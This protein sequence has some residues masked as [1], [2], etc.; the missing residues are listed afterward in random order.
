M[1]KR[2]LR[3]STQLRTAL[4]SGL[5]AFIAILVIF[6]H[7]F[8]VE[9]LRAIGNRAFLGGFGT[10]LIITVLVSILGGGVGLALGKLLELNNYLSRSSLQSLRV[11]RWLPFFVFW[12]LP[13]W[14][15][16]NTRNG[17]PIVI[18]LTTIT[19]G[20]IAAGPTILLGACYYHLSYRARLRTEPRSVFLQI[21]GS[22]FLLALLI[23]LLF[24]LLFND[25]W[26]WRWYLEPATVSANSVAAFILVLAVIVLTIVIPRSSFDP[27][28][29]TAIPTN[30]SDFSNWRSR[31]G[32]V[33]IA[34]A[35]VV[36]WQLWNQTLQEVLLIT[37]PAEVARAIKQLL[38]TGS[39][40][41]GETQHLLWSDLTVSLGEVAGGILVAGTAAYLSIKILGER[42]TKFIY[43]TA[44]AP[45][46]LA[47]QVMFWL[48]VGFWQK[49]FTTALFPVC[50]MAVALCSRRR[51][52]LP[53]NLLAAIEE[54]LPYAFIGMVFAECW[55]STAGLGFDILLAGATR[56]I[57][58]AIATSFI[59]F[60]LLAIM[61]CVLRIVIK[62]MPLYTLGASHV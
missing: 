1:E 55:A 37:P 52:R 51:A 56:H 47:V 2:N 33:L 36:F 60:G 28:S 29:L 27:D 12:A 4:W 9:V 7:S 6:N 31:T 44:V 30:E 11:G 5:F 53:R 45:I 8:F 57:A 24:L 38:I 39:K 42:Y 19:I 13:I 62:R 43:L 54:G 10:F 50:P 14:R 26:P 46:T 25:G 48:G 20:V 35:G 40:A 58:E 61:S 21:T 23:C 59:T 15:G 41:F 22:I 16:T 32:V 18:W 17:P 3:P 49:A 34:V